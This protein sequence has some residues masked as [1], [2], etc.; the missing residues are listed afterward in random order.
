[1][2]KPL[3]ELAKRV[4]HL[5][6]EKGF[7]AGWYSNQYGPHYPRELHLAVKLALVHAEVSEAL[8]ALR[9]EG[10][11]AHGFRE[12]LA[13]ILIRVLDIAG[14]VGMDVDSEV[15]SKH[16]VNVGRPLLHGKRF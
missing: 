10:V 9:K 6:K 5:A 8:E 2:N 4:H 14:A 15:D 13:D 16:E 1:M 12:E 3:N 11:E 7:W